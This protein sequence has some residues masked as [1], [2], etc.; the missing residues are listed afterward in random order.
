[1][2]ENRLRYCI[3]TLALISLAVLFVAATGCGPAPSN[4]PTETPVPEPA[5]TEEPQPTEKPAVASTDQPTEEPEA[6]VTSVAVPI[7]EGE[8]K[9]TPTEEPLSTEEPAAA[10]TE[11]ATEEPETA[12]TSAAAPTEETDQKSTPTE[13]SHVKPKTYS[14]PPEMMIDPEKSYTAIFKTEKGDVTIELFADKAPVTVNSF[15]FLAREGY[16]DGTTFHRVIEDFMA[17]GGDVTGTG[18]GGPGYQFEDEFDPDLKHDK[19][20]TLSMANAGPGTNGS[21]FFITFGPTPWLDGKHTVFGRVVDG[22]DVVKSIR[23]RDPMT[24]PEPGDGIETI[25]I[26]EE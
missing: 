21:Q 16:Y 19:E 14:K 6:A 18:R 15:V 24:D 23:L 3:K 10:S 26:E 9:L 20:G 17:Q 7:E 12:A 5:A 25:V 8:Q 2:T 13:E 11:Q 1:M 22:M 4:P